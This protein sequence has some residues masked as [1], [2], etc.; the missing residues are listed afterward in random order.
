VIV[1]V[2]A[3]G[4]E[5]LLGQIVNGNAAHIGSVLADHGL[6]AHYQ[7]VVGD[8]LDRVAVAITT[9]I[10][11]ADAV[12][13]T[14]GIGPTRDDLTREALCAATGREMVFDEEYADQLR[15]WFAA[16][17]REMPDSNLR[18]AEHP[19]GAELIPNSKGTAPALAL[20]HEGTLV[21][22]I[23]GVPEEMQHL[24]ATE[25]M[26]RIADRAEGPAVVVSRMLRTW[27]QSESMVGEILDD[28]YQGSTNP[29]VA[30]L[31]SAGEIKVRITAKAD[32]HSAAMA[33]IDPVADEVMARLSPFYFGSDDDTVQKVLARLLSE[34][35][36]FIGTAESMTGGL[37]AAALTASPGS[38]Q[39]VKGGLVAYDPELK[40][41]LLG[42]TD[43]STVVDLETALEMADGGRK[44]LDAD[45]VVAV[46]GSAGPDALE[47][48]PGTVIIAVATPEDTRA[49]ELRMPGD[50]ERV[51]TY[52][53]TSALH[54]ARLAVSGQWWT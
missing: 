22:C 8:N 24:L 42:V 21:F 27:G 9:A 50:R 7:Q 35:G 40:Q 48:P 29:S 38:S 39:Y 54:L 18:Q 1:E 14:G 12:I 36:W 44:L 51:M 52:G 10:T 32:S 3:V 30:F 2:V 16:R 41:R 33:L 53:T 5:L 17:G 47:K 15:S 26:P 23:P 46:T 4:T 49:R 11:R 28:L 13:I 43:I 45:V 34:R 6:D 20:D 37:V 31:A 25:V 19:E